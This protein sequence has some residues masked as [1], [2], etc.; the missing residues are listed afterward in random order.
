MRI[1]IDL[2]SHTMWSGDSTTTPDEVDQAV[3][4]AAID[5][6]A[7]TDHHAIKGAEQLRDSLPCAVIVGEEVRTHA[8]E[9]IGL[10]LTERVPFGMSAHDTARAIRDQGGLVYVPHPFDPMRRCIDAAALDALVDDGLV[11]AIEAFNA[12]TSIGHLN[13]RA[14]AYAVE[15]GLAAG[16]GSDAHV[17]A[18]I[19]AARVEVEVAAV[20]DVLSPAGL[21]DA[22]G[23]GTVVGTHHDPPRPWR[24]RIVPSTR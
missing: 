5:V 19:G 10:F 4:A 18:A 8:G 9:I 22:L 2:H 24:P 7:I 17:P 20:D 1:A 15:R 13:E 16:G 3:R 23:R 11:D 21:L 14:A 12:K 6:L